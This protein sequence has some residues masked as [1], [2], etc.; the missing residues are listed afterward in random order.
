MSNFSGSYRFF[1]S[2]ICFLEDARCAFFCWSGVSVIKLDAFL[3]LAEK[4]GVWPC[5]IWPEMCY[6]LS[7]VFYG[8]VRR[9]E[10][11]LIVVICQVY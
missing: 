2:F 11:D 6:C 4:L 7:L 8:N 10:R 5:G 9:L 1:L 3:I